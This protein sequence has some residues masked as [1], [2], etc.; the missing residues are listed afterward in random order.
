MIT[1]SGIVTSEIIQVGNLPRP[2][3][4]REAVRTLAAVATGA[5]TTGGA[6][7]L[8]M[9]SAGVVAATGTMS[10]GIT[11]EDLSVSVSERS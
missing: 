3:G 5:V 11:A 4:L 6:T 10:G 9:A 2:T 1:I 7:S 8:G